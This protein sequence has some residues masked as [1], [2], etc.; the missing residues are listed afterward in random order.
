MHYRKKLLECMKLQRLSTR[1]QHL[2]KNVTPLAATHEPHHG[3]NVTT[4]FHLINGQQIQD[5]SNAAA[6]MAPNP[7]RP[8]NRENHLKGSKQMPGASRTICKRDKCMRLL[9]AFVGSA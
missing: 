8:S 5:Y 1:Q 4:E 6:F 2:K 3:N 9:L 7:L